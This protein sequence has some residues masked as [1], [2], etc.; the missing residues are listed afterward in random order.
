VARLL[1]GWREAMP[2]RRACGGTDAALLRAGE[3]ER[4][5]WEQRASE[6]SE[7]ASWSASWQ[8]EA[9]PDRCRGAGAGVRT[10]LGAHGQRLVGHNGQAEITIRPPSGA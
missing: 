9:A 2:Q 6:E 5:R 3:S 10:P 1:C 4:G 7:L 8:L